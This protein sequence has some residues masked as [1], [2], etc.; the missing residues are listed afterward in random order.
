MDSSILSFPERGP[1]GDSSFPGN[2][3]GYVIKALLEYHQPRY[4]VDPAEG[5]GTSGDVATELGI[6]YLGLDLKDGF[7]IL[8]HAL[9]DVV[10]K[11]PDLVFFHPPY[12]NI[13]KYSGN[14]W[15]ESHPDDL[16][17]CGS[18][19]E[20]LSKLKH[21]CMNI[22]KAVKPSGHLAILIGDIRRNGNYYSPQSEVQ[23][24]PIGEL[25]SVIIKLQHHCRS[26]NKRYA[27]RFI[28]IAHE[29][30]LIFRK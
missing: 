17:R 15:G 27:G 22:W 4:F 9:W 28:P 29:Y 2:C 7:N 12:H 10:D 1:S 6:K 5:S 25:E 30:L 20:Y 8:S 18:Y 26:S 24:F 13:I 14:V 3:S 21:A 19:E 16:S 23:R 11:P